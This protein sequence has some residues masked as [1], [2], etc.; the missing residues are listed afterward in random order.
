MWLL[1]LNYFRP[2][3]ESCRHYLRLSSSVR[4]ITHILARQ[5]TR[6]V[7]WL[8]ERSVQLLAV[9]YCM[10]LNRIRLVTELM[11]CVCVH[12]VYWL[13]LSCLPIWKPTDYCK[14]CYLYLHSVSYEC[15]SLQDAEFSNKMHRQQQRRHQGLLCQ[16]HQPYKDMEPNTGYKAG[17][18]SGRSLFIKQ[19]SKGLS[20]EVCNNVMI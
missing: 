2:N 16:H 8:G 13:V 5:S 6:R 12:C 19:M 14:F 11:H 3:I 10:S 7:R 9:N 18:A 4:I 1:W 17:E 15:S 20:V